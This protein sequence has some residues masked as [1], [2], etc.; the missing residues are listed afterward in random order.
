MLFRSEK[1]LGDETIDTSN[2]SKTYSTNESTGLNYQKLGRKLMNLNELKTM[3]RNKCIVTISG[4]PPFLSDKY[5]TPEHPNFKYTAD[6]AESNIF[7][8]QKHRK[9]L[10]E[11]DGI[12]HVNNIKFKASDEYMVLSV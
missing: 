1:A 10:I 8:F 6:A 2:D 3:D 12:K 7:D 11:R 4:I 9:E 5:P